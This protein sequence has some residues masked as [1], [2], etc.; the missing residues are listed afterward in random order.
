[1]M[2]GAWLENERGRD[3]Y[4]DDEDGGGHLGDMEAGAWEAG[5]EEMRY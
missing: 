4:S 2:R 3:V 5:R 1:M